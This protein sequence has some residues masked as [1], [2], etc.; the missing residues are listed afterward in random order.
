M[1]TP[2]EVLEVTAH[3][4]DEE[5]RRAYLDLV[6]R[7]PPEKEAEKFQQV[8]AAYD[9]ISDERKRI[10]YKLFHCQLPAKADIAELLLE[11]K[12]SVKA[13]EDIYASLRAAV[14]QYCTTFTLNDC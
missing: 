7:Y 14:K 5:I 12:N 2:Y 8:Y 1:K 3:A 9:L 6:R 11:G 10:A 4:D 13:Q